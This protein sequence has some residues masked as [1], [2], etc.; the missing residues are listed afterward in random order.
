MYVELTSRASRPTSR[1]DARAQMDRRGAGILGTG[2]YVG[3]QVLRGAQI[4]PIKSKP[5]SMLRKQDIN[6]PVSVVVDPMRGPPPKPPR[7]SS[8]RRAPRSVWETLLKPP[9]PP[10]PSTAAGVVV[11]AAFQA[12]RRAQIAAGDTSLT[13]SQLITVR[14]FGGNPQSRQ[15]NERTH[16]ISIA[17]GDDRATLGPLGCYVPHP[18]SKAQAVAW[19]EEDGMRRSQSVASAFVEVG[20]AAGTG[21]GAPPATPRADSPVQPATR[22]STAGGNTGRGQSSSAA[23]LQ[24][25]EMQRA[26]EL[27]SRPALPTQRTNRR[28]PF[29]TGSRRLSGTSLRPSTSSPSY[30]QHTH[31]SATFAMSRAQSPPSPGL[32]ARNESEAAL[33]LRSATVGWGMT[34]P[35][36]AG[37]LKVT[38]CFT[39]IEW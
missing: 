19:G 14:G 3:P 18:P 12:T 35:A 8:A 9:E 16:G 5:L 6:V 7:P 17:A 20:L 37:R 39:T 38:D 33:L 13:R 15:R 32:A 30:M 26:A 23:W 21:D 36:S 31:S 28:D 11:A 34:R 24:Q 25:R 27:A 22:P 4:A 1:A 10:R 29:L 2:A